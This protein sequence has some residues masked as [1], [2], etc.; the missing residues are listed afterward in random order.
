MWNGLQLRN[1]GEKKEMLQE[2]QERQALWQLSKSL[3]S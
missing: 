1:E 3:M 2:I